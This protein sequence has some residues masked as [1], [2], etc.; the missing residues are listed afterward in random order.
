M[1]Y[2]PCFAIFEGKSLSLQS[3]LQSYKVAVKWSSKTHQCT[4]DIFNLDKDN[5]KKLSADML[6]NIEHVLIN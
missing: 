1:V 5:F 2:F 4:L 6:W 3:Y